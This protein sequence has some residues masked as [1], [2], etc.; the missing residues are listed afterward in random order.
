MKIL[1]A[2]KDAHEVIICNANIE[3]RER[4]KTRRACNESPLRLSV[5]ARDK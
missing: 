3:H 4:F 1:F 5:F 2:R